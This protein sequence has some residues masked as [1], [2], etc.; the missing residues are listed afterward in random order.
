MVGATLLFA[1]MGVCVKKASLEA[2][3]GQVVF[4][5]GAVGVVA[6]ALL[7]WRK[8]I[9]LKTSVPMLHIKRGASGVIALSLWFYTIG[10]L[11]LSTAVTLNYMS[12]VWMAVFLLAKLAFKRWRGQ[13]AK[14]IPLMLLAAIAVGF[15][16][17]TL[18]LRPS[19]ERNLWLEGGVGVLSGMLSAI[20][21][22]QVASLGKSGEPEVRVVFYFSLFGLASGLLMTLASIWQGHPGWAHTSAQSWWWLI[23]TG[24]CATIAQVGLTRAYAKG[25]PLAMASLQY[26]AIAHAFVLGLLVFDDPLHLV[27]VIGM[28]LIVAAGITAT[29]SSAAV[30]D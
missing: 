14:P 22:F 11:P 4:F 26:L 29:R 19:I 10:Q 17:V 27:S 28:V 6:M 23:G 2:T 1:F 5:R 8:E 15:L 20:A 9:S 30:K 12:S 24:C 18:V 16:G 25:Q 7:A 21:Y 13:A 3:T